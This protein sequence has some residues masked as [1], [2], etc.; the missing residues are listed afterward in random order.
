[1]HY[2]KKSA[3]IGLR[4]AAFALSLCLGLSACLTL[5]EEQ[6]APVM[7]SQNANCTLDGGHWQVSSSI[8]KMTVRHNY[9]SKEH[10]EKSA[11]KN[12]PSLATA[13]KG[14]SLH[15]ILSGKMVATS[16]DFQLDPAE[17]ASKES[18]VHFSAI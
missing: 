14:S 13:T 17:K 5:K 7:V 15:N 8:K 6:A 11:D 1:M 4:F 2:S 16:F 18:R 9:Q 12:K 3:L 10:C